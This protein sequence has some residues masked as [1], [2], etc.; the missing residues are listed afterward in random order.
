MK[1]K[2]F[3]L[4]VKILP[5]LTVILLG[6]ILFQMVKGCTCCK[7]GMELIGTNIDYSMGEGV[8]E[9]WEH[10]EQTKGSCIDYRYHNHDS[11]QSEHVNVNDS[12]HFLS[13][14]EFAPECCG[15]N[16]SSV[17]VI[18]ENNA[19]RGGCACMTKKQIDYLNTRG[20]NRT[21]GEF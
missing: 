20:G 8:K 6:M 5:L 17:G 14:T 13:K 10:K 18:R 11:Y 2:I 7:E 21:S 19:T 12:M 16:Y 15:S 3:D 1:I 4:K 9:S